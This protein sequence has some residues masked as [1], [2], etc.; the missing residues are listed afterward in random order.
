M[1]TRMILYSKRRLGFVDCSGSCM[2]DEVLDS[3]LER[4]TSI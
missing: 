1:Y 2:S 4:G 3:L